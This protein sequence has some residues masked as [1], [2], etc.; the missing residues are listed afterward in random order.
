MAKDAA[1]DLIYYLV[2]DETRKADLAQIRHWNNLRIAFEEGKI[3]VRGLDAVQVES[4]EVK[5]MPYKTLY[6]ENSGKLYLYKSALPDRNLPSLLWTPV[7]RALPLR[8]PSLNHNYFGIDEKIAVRIV[9]SEKETEAAAMITTL[10]LLGKYL[11]TAPAIRLKHLKWVMLNRDRALILGNPV[12]PISGTVFWQRGAH[13]LPAGS[14]FDLFL[15]SE[16]LHQQIDPDRA[17]LIV[18][19]TD[20]TCFTVDKTD[21]QSL[22]LSSFRKSMQTLTLPTP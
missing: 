4:V 10:D 3:W 15:L 12:L 14:D 2:L 9:P 22:S 8:L 13:L 7:D 17:S 5:S 16:A 21:F 18:W 11:E 6:S 19:Q 20:S 1:N